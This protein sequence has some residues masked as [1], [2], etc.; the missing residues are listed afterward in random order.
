LSAGRAAIDR[1]LLPAELT[2]TNPQ[3]RVCCCV[4]ERLLH[5]RRSSSSGVRMRAVT[6]CQSA[7]VTAYE[8]KTE[9]KC[10]FVADFGV[11][12]TERSA[13]GLA[14]CCLRPLMEISAAPRACSSWDKRW[15]PN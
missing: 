11:D 15:T 10:C 6:R 13:D 4:P 9:T 8:H 5:G 1:Y 2:A 7:C 14:G 3:Q 12:G